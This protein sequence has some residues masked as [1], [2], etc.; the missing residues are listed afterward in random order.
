MNLSGRGSSFVASRAHG[1]GKRCHRLSVDLI[2]VS[3][4]SNRSAW[5]RQASKFVEL[6]GGGSWNVVVEVRG[7]LAGLSVGAYPSSWRRECCTGVSVRWAEIE[8]IIAQI[9]IDVW[10]IL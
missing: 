3:V 8:S 9:V 10:N 7:G 6:V 1:A 2:A 4:A 5:D